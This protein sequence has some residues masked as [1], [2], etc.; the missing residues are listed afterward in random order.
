MIYRYLLVSDCVLIAYSLW[1]G[2]MMIKKSVILCNFI[3]LKKD[4][5]SG[6]DKVVR[7]GLKEVLKKMGVEKRKDM[8]MKIDKKRRV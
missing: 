6:V 4:E 8:K 3:V 5:K 1:T 2:F 7:N